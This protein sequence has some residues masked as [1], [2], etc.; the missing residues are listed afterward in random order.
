LQK[1]PWGEREGVKGRRLEG[2]VFR[3]MGEYNFCNFRW[4]REDEDEEATLD[5]RVRF[6]LSFFF[7]RAKFGSVDSP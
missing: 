2:L 6:F 4:R 3:R 1:V 5:F 7:I